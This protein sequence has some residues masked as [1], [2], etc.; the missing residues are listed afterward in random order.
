MQ[1]ALA[2]ATASLYRAAFLKNIKLADWKIVILV[3]EK[4]KHIV[5][6]S[7][8]SIEFSFFQS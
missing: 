6:R 8:S 3:V 5:Q 4:F 2:N 7:D 1:Q